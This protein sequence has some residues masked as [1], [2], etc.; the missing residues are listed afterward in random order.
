M[1]Y[2]NKYFIYMCNWEVSRNFKVNELTTQLIVCVH[3]QC[4][5]K[6]LIF[7]ALKTK[8]LN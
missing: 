2:Y 3:R 1:K 5:V 7:V 6:A 4:C 8:T